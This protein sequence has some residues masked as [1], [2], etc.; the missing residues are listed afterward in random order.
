MAWHALDVFVEAGLSADHNLGY[1]WPLLGVSDPAGRPEPHFA[2]IVAA[3]LAAVHREQA[4][5]DSARAVAGKQVG[6]KS[7]KKDE[8]TS[9]KGTAAAPRHEMGRALKGAAQEGEGGRAS[10]SGGKAEGKGRPKT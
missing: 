2:P 7:S 4:A 8:H 10:S 3:G 6:A 5:A 1:A 9:A